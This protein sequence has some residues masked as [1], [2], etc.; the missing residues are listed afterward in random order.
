MEYENDFEYSNSKLSAKKVSDNRTV[1]ASEVTKEDGPF[2]CP[3]TFE[4]L[5]VRKCVEKIDH[6]AYKARTSPI[7]T[8]ESQ[9]HKACKN[10]LIEILT[11]EY[12][13]GKWEL[14]RQTFLEDREKEYKRVIPDLSGRIG[15][16]GVIIEIQKS[17]LSLKNI[18]HRT[19]QYTKRGAYI[20]WIVPLMEELGN[21]SFRPRL[22]ERFLHT[23]YYGKVYYWYKGNGS[24]LIPVHFG[25]AER[26]IEES[27]WY[28]EAGEEQITGGYEKPYLR[29]KK[30]EYGKTI[31]LLT[32]FKFDDRKEFAL[33]NEQLSA[34]K[35]KIYVDK[36]PNWWTEE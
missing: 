6:F 32:D 16:K 25:T 7:A 10:E 15:D 2:Y 5:I 28:N 14:E 18:R 27:V 4:E 31:D 8:K 36:I 1:F 34:P 20:L 21:E 35:S 9:L 13:N 30:P 11:K 23:M 33:E 29:V 26:W 3:E 24:K 17:T 12:P 22:F 19:E